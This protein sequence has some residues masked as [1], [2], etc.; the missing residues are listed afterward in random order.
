MSV[1]ILRH[2]EPDTIPDKGERRRMRL[3]LHP[4]IVVMACV[5]LSAFADC[6]TTANSIVCDTAAPNPFTSRVGAGPG[7]GNAT[8]VTLRSGAMISTGESEGVSLGN[9]SVLVLE[10]GAS[11]NNHSNGTSGAGLWG[12]GS[13]AVDIGS[14]GRIDI[15]VG[16]TIAAHGPD[17]AAEAINVIGTATAIINRGAITSDQ[18][19][20]LRLWT[21]SDTGRN[22]VDNYGT[23][24][25]GLGRTATVFGSDGAGA[26]DF[27]N[28]A[29]ASITGALDFGDGDDLF[30]IEAGSTVDGNISG[31]GGA[32][33]LNLSGAAATAGTLASDVSGFQTLNKRGASVWTLTG[34]LAGDPAVHVQEGTLVMGADYTGLTRTVTIDPGAVLQGSTATLPGDIVDNGTLV[35]D[36][37][38]DGTYARSVAGAGVLAKRGAGTLTLTG[39]S[40]YG[41]GTRLQS[42]FVQASADSALG[43]A[44]GA[45]SFDGGGLRLGAAFDL[46]PDRAIAIGAGGGTIDTQGFDTTIAQGIGGQGLGAL[47]K[48]GTG[49]LTLLGSTYVNRTTISAGTLQIGNGG[50]AGNFVGNSPI[51][52]NAA[53]AF[54]HSNDAMFGSLISGTG[55]VRQIGSG[56][57]TLFGDNRY[58]GATTVAAGALFV[59]GNQTAA[60]GATTVASGA[61]L[62]GAGILGGAA[63]LADGA[64]LAPGDAGSAPGTLTVNGDLA[65]A[66]GATLNYSFG[67]PDVVGGSLNDLVEVGG[68]LILDGTLNV[69]VPLGGAFD[70]GVYRVFN[71]AGALTDNTLGL[72]AVP[73]GRV[74]VQTSVAHQVNLVFALLELSYWDGDA[75]PNDNNAVDGGDGTWQASGGNHHWTDAAG[76]LNTAF[77]DGKFAVF[78]A[79]PGAVTVDGSLGAVAVSGM[80]FAADGYRIGGD[81]IALLGTAETPARTIVRVGDGT[82][83]GA[84][85]VATIDAELTGASGLVKA[86]AGTLVL[87]A[88]NTFAGGVSV[89]GG[90][91]Q[92]AR[93]DNLGE[94]AGALH[95]DNGALRTTADVSSARAATLA[96]GG[97]TLEQAA[98]TT[99]TFDGPIAGAGAL[100][101]RGDGTLLL[102]GENT[103]SGGTRVNGGV[104]Q[105]ASDANL[106]AAAGV[107]GFDGGS[108]RITADTATA[109]AVALGAGGG[110]LEQV[111]GTTHSLSGVIAGEGAL[112]KQGAGTLVLTA[113][114]TFTGST[115]IAQGLLQLGDGGSGGS[116]T[117]AVVDH[118]TLAI[119]RADTLVLAGAISGSGTL[120]QSGTGITVLAADNSFAGGTTIDAGTLQLG[121]GGAGGSVIGDI[122]DHGT[123]AFNRSAVYVFG[124]NASG[125]G[126]L[127]QIG[128]GTTVL[129]GRYDLAGSHLIAAGTLAVGD[130]AHAGAVLRSSPATTTVQAGATLGGYGT[131]TEAVV[132]R[133]TIAV[134]DAVAAFAGRGS[135]T[136]AIGGV[137]T[138]AGQVQIGGAGVG[139]RLV[140][141][142][143]VGQNGSLTLNTVLGGD[144]SASDRLVI[145]GGSAAGTTRVF[146]NNVGGVGERSRGN[147]ILVV[148][149]I[150]G[151]TT[152]ADAFALG[153]RVIGGPYEYRLLRGG[154]DGSAAEAWFLRSQDE[155][156]PEQPQIRTE[157]AAYA[158]LPS[159]ALGYGRASIGSLHERMGGTAAQDAPHEAGQEGGRSWL[160]VFGKS[161][162]WNAKSGGLQAEGPSFDQNAF[163]LQVGAAV[164]AAEHANG[165]HTRI[166]LIGA[167]G[168]GEGRVERDDS[169]RAGTSRFDTYSFGASATWY[170][171][172]GAYLDAVA[173]AGAYDARAG[174]RDLGWLK[175]DGVGYAASIEG[176]MAYTLG[177]GWRIE[178]QAQV[179]YQSI[180]LD[181]AA[182]PA[183]QVRFDRSESLAWRLGARASRRWDNDGGHRVS[184]WFRGNLW[185]ETRG[186]SKI[187]VSSSDG[188]VPFRSRI[189]G[190][191][192]ELGAGIDVALAERVALYA[193]FGYEKAAGDGIESANGNVGV[194]MSW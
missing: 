112:T 122:V 155:V 103:Y 80:Q 107:L 79:R 158:A 150:R 27:T 133:G 3:A 58:A 60:T 67:E 59:N 28:Y 41:G 181:T 73:E 180:D 111:D 194:R 84:A 18:T 64:I 165:S 173:Q 176:G 166:G 156:R 161:G 97:G 14:D 188:F 5:P 135:G 34:A 184:M 113:N 98:G 141:G 129:N 101:K 187:E 159:M 63:T 8:S 132:N 114:N 71:Y 124:G 50:D 6:I 9:Q 4:L 72:G 53:L 148:E 20:A 174:S 16:A 57:T 193:D 126:G 65:L 147:G 190:S 183:A 83:G 2:R 191:W 49:T 23:I 88:R 139:N 177:K 36:Q 12:V 117:G 137:L 86:D 127:A 151:A 19:A 15:G 123:L 25:T 136:F 13:D 96:S 42:G 178:P 186:D 108:L 47:T 38:G 62:G 119:N 145:D 138:N 93:D 131:V 144:D 115:T 66:A 82:S 29:G 128:S 106:G 134:A 68:N 120:R 17:A 164:L 26:V 100:S 167:A 33:V 185:R 169:G 31:G 104:L 154:R 90:V 157:V 89:E 175:T 162:E 105:V 160:R 75:G 149:P 152:G 11:I 30:T 130:A 48:Q 46:S 54:N 55:E 40:S 77:A 10:S 39:A 163:A 69:D 168:R 170:A 189:G 74:F 24:S 52:N 118:G 1:H 182:D 192:Y 51:V 45:L 91:L 109:R 78:Q 143:Y 61:T 95:F 94:A 99:L 35:F 56:S 32:N 121:N 172:G 21:E 85:Y 171:A 146:V 153:Q 70:P 179:V 87:G 92:V 43:A 44:T 125:R 140:V 7:A 22:T 37:A 142:G 116:L 102:T 110:S 76:S 81:P